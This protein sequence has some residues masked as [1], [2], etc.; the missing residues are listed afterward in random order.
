M[1]RVVFA[2]WLRAAHLNWQCTPRSNASIPSIPNIVALNTKSLQCCGFCWEKMGSIPAFKKKTQLLIH[3]EVCVRGGAAFLCWPSTLNT[4][5]N[6][7]PKSSVNVWRQLESPQQRRELR[8]S[9]KTN[10]CLDGTRVIRVYLVGMIVLYYS[11]RIST[12]G[13]SLLFWRVHSGS[14]SRWCYIL[15]DILAAQA[16]S[17]CRA[18]VRWLMN[19]GH[20]RSLSDCWRD[21]RWKYRVFCQKWPAQE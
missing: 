19:Q 1:S 3:Q 16:R 18:C 10:S 2:G 12:C 5:E 4:K 14:N 20:A 21:E 13:G 11:A 15:E 9:C 8:G 17:N 7:L 6:F